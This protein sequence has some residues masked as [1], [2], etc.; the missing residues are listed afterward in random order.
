[1]I[2]PT[3]NRLAQGLLRTV[4]HF[5]VYELLLKADFTSGIEFDGHYYK[6]GNSGY[7][8]MVSRVQRAMAF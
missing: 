4:V 5:C 8:V 1:M 3:E 6:I 2:A 7:G